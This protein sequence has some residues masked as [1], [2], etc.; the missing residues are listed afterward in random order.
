MPYAVLPNWSVLAALIASAAIGA[1]ST[2]AAANPAYL[3]IWSTDPALC[4]RDTPAASAA[5]LDISKRWLVKF[6]VV[7]EQLSSRGGRGF[8]HN[9]YSCE[10]AGE[11]RQAHFTLRTQANTLTIVSS[12]A[13]PGDSP[14]P[15]NY[16]RCR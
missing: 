9:D 15:D 3:G 14:V 2:S 5:R 1:P 16:V 11:T 8:W 10:T 13:I 4:G 12:N 6:E 7:C